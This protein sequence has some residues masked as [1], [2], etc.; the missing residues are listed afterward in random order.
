MGKRL[1]DGTLP[2]IASNLERIADALDAR[3]KREDCSNL[4]E[5][6]NE[7]V[8]SIP[9]DDGVIANTGSSFNAPPVFGTAKTSVEDHVVDDFG[10]E[11]PLTIQEVKNFEDQYDKEWEGY[12]LCPRRYVRVLFTDEPHSWFG[13]TT[14][15]ANI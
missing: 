3:A 4:E 10:P 11:H 12:V 7:A 8:E 15:R 13:Y 6:F 14:H 9:S 5:K 2:M 1:I